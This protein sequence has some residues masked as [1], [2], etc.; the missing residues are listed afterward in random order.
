MYH[1]SLLTHAGPRAILAM[2]GHSPTRHGGSDEHDVADA[3]SFL[4]DVRRR[5]ARVPRRLAFPESADPR[6]VAAV[7]EL[8]EQN[9]V[10]PVLVL[11][12]CPA[13][14]SSRRS[15]HRCVHSRIRGRSARDGG[16]ARARRRRRRVRGRRGLH[17]RRCLTRSAPCR[18][19]REGRANRFQRVLHDPASALLLRTA[20]G[21]TRRARRC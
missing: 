18:R 12:P 5:A 16:C 9:L 19:A 7:R 17:V 6:T 20:V 2:H 4:A 1:A 21:M 14:E 8:V 10:E 3:M 11:G 15:G 13:R